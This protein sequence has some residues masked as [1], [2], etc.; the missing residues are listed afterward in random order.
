MSVPTGQLVGKTAV[1]TGS[2]RG[3][4]Q[5]IALE[6]AEAGAAVLVHGWRHPEEARVAA[7]TIRQKGREVLV[8]LADLADP[9]QQD[10]LVEEAWQ[11][12]Q[13]VDIWINN[14][15]ADVLTGQ[16]LNWPFEQRLEALWRLDVVATIRLSRQ[17]GQRMKRAGQGVIVN[18]G[19]DGVHRGIETDGGQLFAAAKGAVMAF[20]RSLARALAPQV[21]VLCIAPGWIRTQWA[22]QASDFWQQR[23]IQECLLG[24]WGTPQDVANLVRFVVSPE[25]SFLTGQIIEIN[26][27]T[28]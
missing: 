25:A 20:S 15:G 16:A 22:Q 11:W 12:R 7:E 2:S 8:V 27:G 10:R 26:G 17:V 19:W 18:V 14:A 1:V 9:S 13:G 21:R 4:G 3:I 28:R 5:A 23:A 24:R 6:L